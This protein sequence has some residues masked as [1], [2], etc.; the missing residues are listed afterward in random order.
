MEYYKKNYTIKDGILDFNITDSI[1]SKVG[2]FYEEQQVSCGALPD[3]PPDPVDC[4]L[5]KWGDWKDK[6]DAKCSKTC[7]SG[8]KEHRGVE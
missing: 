4:V 3:C 8:V 2:N 5:S 1:T 7:G 6:P